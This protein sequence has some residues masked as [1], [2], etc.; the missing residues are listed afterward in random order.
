M[1][2][3]TSENIKGCIHTGHKTNADAEM[4]VTLTHS[5]ATNLML[6]QTQR[7]DNSKF[8]EGGRKFSKRVENTLGKKEIAH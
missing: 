2:I 5:Q 7:E 4:H 3:C 6:F 1:N 8:N